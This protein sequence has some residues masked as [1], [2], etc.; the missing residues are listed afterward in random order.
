M[1]K[2]ERLKGPGPLSLRNLRAKET[3]KHHLDIRQ[4][5]DTT[6]VLSKYTSDIGL[7]TELKW[8][9]GD[10]LKLAKSVLDKL[11]AGDP[12][13]ALE[14]LR[15]SEKMPGADGSKGVDSVVSWNHVMDYYMSKSLT[16]EA[17]RVFNEASY[18]L[19]RLDKIRQR[20]MLMRRTDEEKRT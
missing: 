18:L 2:T 19:R 17:F 12:S 7:Q 15:L 3:N 16:R 13:K 20:A 4:P 6:K 1:S 9:G 11:K 5:D 14:M 10:A 8:T